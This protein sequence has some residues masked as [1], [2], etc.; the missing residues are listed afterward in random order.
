M[1]NQQQNY[2]EP[3]TDIFKFFN[4]FFYYLVGKWRDE[5]LSAEIKDLVLS[6]KQAG[7]VKKMEKQQDAWFNLHS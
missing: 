4:T 1:N 3:D 2:L 5:Q 6:A 7:R